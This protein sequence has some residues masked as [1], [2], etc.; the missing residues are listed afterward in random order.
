MRTGWLTPASQVAFAI[1]SG[2]NKPLPR[3]AVPTDTAKQ[4]RL[5]NNSGKGFP[6]RILSATGGEE[7]LPSPPIKSQYTPEA[8]EVQTRF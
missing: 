7:C 1:V 5:R 4:Y 6:L 8:V 3:A 2:N